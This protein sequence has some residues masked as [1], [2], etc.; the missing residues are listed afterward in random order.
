MMEETSDRLKAL[1]RIPSYDGRNL[2]IARSP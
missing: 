2:T 1:I